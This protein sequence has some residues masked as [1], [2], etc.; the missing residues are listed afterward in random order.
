MTFLISLRSPLKRSDILR[1][2]TVPIWEKYMLTID[3]AAQYF[4]IGENR[5]RRFINENPDD[6]YIFYWGNRKLIKRRKFE[7]LIDKGLAV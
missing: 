1:E 4:H 3:E 5:L 7:E 2:Q 6:S